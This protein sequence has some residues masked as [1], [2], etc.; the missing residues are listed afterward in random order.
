MT[1]GNDIFYLNITM[2]RVL[3]DEKLIKGVHCP[4][5]NESSSTDFFPAFLPHNQSKVW[6]SEEGGHA[7]P[8]QWA[9]FY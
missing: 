5:E 9:V 6:T 1:I 2:V 7:P 3:H 4:V 8:P